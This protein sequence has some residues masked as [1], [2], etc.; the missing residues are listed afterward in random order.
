MGVIVNHKV[1]RF[2][3]VVSKVPQG[4]V[5]DPLLFLLYINFLNNDVH[6]PT[7]IFADDLKLC[8]QALL[9]NN[10]TIR[11][12]VETCQRDI[13]TV[14]QVAKSWGLQMNYTKCA[15][16]HFC[17]KVIDFSG[18][19]DVAH[20]SLG[21]DMLPEKDIALDL[22]I[23]VDVSLKFHKHISTIS[24]IASAVANS[25]LKSTVNRDRTFM[26]TLYVSQIRPLLEYSSSV[27]SLGCI[28]ALVN[29]LESVQRRWTKCVDGLGN[30]PNSTRLQFLN[31]FS[32]KGRLLRPD[33]IKMWQ[34][35]HGKSYLNF[36]DF[37]YHPGVSI[38]RGHQHKLAHVRTSFEIR[39]CSFVVRK[40]GLWNSLPESVVT[41]SSL[42]S[43]KVA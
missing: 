15:V 22:G 17:Q 13:N 8:V 26:S 20:Y 24:C 30:L 23:S 27:W 11:D 5:L 4:S 42:E 7:R 36:D 35:V 40:I 14:Y 12:R 29:S 37:F 10:E 1:S 38:T 6:C 32:V 16:L 19:E 41:S 9:S 43:F 39:K 18:L 3:P 31:S 25:L 28:E 34:I 21:N 2:H 33:L